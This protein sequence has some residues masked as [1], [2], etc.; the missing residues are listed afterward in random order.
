MKQII[1]D[2]TCIHDSETPF[3]IRGH[4]I[5][6]RHDNGKIIFEKDNMIVKTGREYI[7]QV[8]LTKIFSSATAAP[9][10]TDDYSSYIIDGIYL[11]SG[12]NDTVYDMTYDTVSP[13]FFVDSTDGT[14]IIYNISGVDTVKDITT[15]SSSNEIKFV[16]SI[17]A[18]DVNP[19]TVHELSIILE[20]NSD[21][22]KKLLFSRLELDDTPL[23]TDTKVD[24]EYYIYF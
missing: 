22:S 2:D 18:D 14:T 20:S 7:R 13:N 10:F 19:V 16:V 8:F 6:R 4:V 24:L 3:N 23:V 5:A 17:P 15:Y 11:G 9:T 12:L 21:S 1:R